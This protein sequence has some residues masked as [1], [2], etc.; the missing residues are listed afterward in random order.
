MAPISRVLSL[1]LNSTALLLVF[2]LTCNF[3]C[4]TSVFNIESQF[5]FNGANLCLGTG[6]RLCSTLF[7][8]SLTCILSNS[9]CLLTL[10]H[11]KTDSNHS[12]LTFIYCLIGKESKNSLAT[13]SKLNIKKFQK[14]ATK[15]KS[16]FK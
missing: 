13:Q 4:S 16:P 15:D 7:P 10:L 3:M 6:T 8:R 9:S 11:I 12:S 14:I 2:I 1:V 5:Y